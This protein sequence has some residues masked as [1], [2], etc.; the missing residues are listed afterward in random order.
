MSTLSMNSRFGNRFRAGVTSVFNWLL[1]IFIISLA[2]YAGGCAVGDSVLMRPEVDPATNE[3]VY[4][5]KEGERV[6]ESVLEKMPE[7]EKEEYEPVYEGP[8]GAE[9]FGIDGS[10]YGVS[11]AGALAVIAGIY[12]A[13][14]RRKKKA[15]S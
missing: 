13:F 9:D 1:Q 2:L 12:A 7:A 4:E 14:R 5:N 15:S 3:R 8:K 10:V 11:I 6:T